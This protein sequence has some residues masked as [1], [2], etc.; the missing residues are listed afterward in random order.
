MDMKY[1]KVKEKK[2]PLDNWICEQFH[3]K[4]IHDTILEAFMRLYFLSFN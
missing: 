1:S 3:Y 2:N 4:F